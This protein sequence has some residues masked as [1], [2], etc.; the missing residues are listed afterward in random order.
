MTKIKKRL[1]AS[2][3]ALAMTVVMA[4]PSFAAESRAIESPVGNS[5][6]MHGYG[7]F[8]AGALTVGVNATGV[9]IALRYFTGS[10]NQKWLVSASGANEG[11]LQ[12]AFVSPSGV[13][14]VLTLDPSPVS[15]GTYPVVLS[16]AN[17]AGGRQRLHFS[18]YDGRT[19]RA[20]LDS[21]SGINTYNGYRL[22]IDKSDTSSLESDIY[23]LSGTFTEAIARPNTLWVWGHMS[24]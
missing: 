11:I 16:P 4:V 21:N 14:M 24:W 6:R 5:I 9:P 3:L 15:S 20:W 7:S 12:S 8:Q 19:F 1:L 2:L 18:N 17:V 13:P 22:Y 10:K 23:F